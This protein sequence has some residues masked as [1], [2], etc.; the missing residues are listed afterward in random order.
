[1]PNKIPMERKKK[2]IEIRKEAR[3]AAN[4]ASGKTFPK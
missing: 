4:G 2:Y 1:L 3:E